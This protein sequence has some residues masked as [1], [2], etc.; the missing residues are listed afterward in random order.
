MRLPVGVRYIENDLLGIQMAQV[1]FSLP[2]NGIWVDCVRCGRRDRLAGD[3]TARMTEEKAR[4]IFEDKGWTVKRPGPRQS[5]RT[6]C[7]EHVP[8]QIKAQREKAR[9][10]R[11]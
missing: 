7:P 3:A 4:A 11:A 5:C 10:V 1:T 2:R 8:E 9:R 6:L